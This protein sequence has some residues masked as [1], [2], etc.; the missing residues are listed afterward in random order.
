MTVHDIDSLDT[1]LFL[2]ERVLFHNE[3]GENNFFFLDDDVRAENLG[4]LGNE[5]QQK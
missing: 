5:K 4:W 3:V 2:P 1:C